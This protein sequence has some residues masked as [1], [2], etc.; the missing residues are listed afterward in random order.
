MVS[1][2]NRCC[3]SNGAILH[4]VILRQATGHKAHSIHFGFWSRHR[5]MLLQYKWSDGTHLLDTSTAHLRALQAQQRFK[6]HRASERWERELGHTIPVDI[7]SRTWSNFRGA[8]ENTFLWQLFYRA[9]ATQRWRF[10]SVPGD[11]PCIRCTRCNMGVKEDIIHC[12]WGCPVSQPCWQWC[13]GL[14]AN[15]SAQRHRPG[16]L[17]GSLEPAHVFVA[18]PLPADWKIPGRLW[19]I[20]RAVICWQVWKTRNEHFMANRPSDPQRTIRKS[21]HRLSMYLRKEWAYLRR[22]ISEG[23]ASLAE[24]EDIMKLNFGSNQEVWQLRGLVI[25]V[26]SVPPRAP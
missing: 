13:V 9:I 14:L 24:A 8:N 20:L 17:R 18:A 5:N 25:H 10:P 7:W 23:K 12:V 2:I 26:P 3:P 6:P 11:D 22:K 1:K 21:W 15:C 19:L 4:R 16:G